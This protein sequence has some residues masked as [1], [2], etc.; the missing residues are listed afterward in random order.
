M[1]ENSVVK[2][3]EMLNE[4]KWT[5]A[6]LNSYSITNLKDLDKIIKQAEE[7]EASDEIKEICDDHLEHTKNSII[8]LYISGIIA[9]KN[10]LVDD[11]NL[12]I[13]IDIFTGNHKWNIVEFLC[14]RI[15]DFGE[16][17]YAL[18]TL[19]E[20]YNNENE[21]EKMHQIWE[22]LIAVDYEEAAIVKHL[23]EIYEE[24]ND[25]ET[26]IDYY[27]KA[28]HR[29]INQKAFASIK[30]IWSKL[31]TYIIDETDFFF[32][33]EQ[34]VAKAISEERAAQL[35]EE[36][37]PDY[38]DK[39][40]YDT[41]IEVLKKILDYDP[42]NQWARKE[43]VECYKQKF[44]DHS[45]LD[46]YIKV[47]NLTMSWRNVQEAIS[48]FEKHISFDAG[49]FVFHRSWGIGRISGIVGDKITIDFAK[50]RN[51]QMSLKMAVNALTVLS[52]DH[53]WVL[54]A[55]WGKEKLHDKVKKDT[56][57]ALKIVIKSNDNAADMKKIKSELVPGILSPGEWTTWSNEARKILKTNPAFGNLPDKVDQFVVRNNPISFEEK[58]F[59]KFKA[60]K[61]IFNKIA[62]VY[63]LMKHGSTESDYFAEMFN[64]FAN[65]LK[66]FNTVN[67]TVLAS[68][69]VVSNIIKSHPYLN[70]NLDISFMDL[71]NEVENLEETFS[72]IED[73]D[74]QRN[75]LVLVKENIDSWPDIYIRL[76]PY[77]LN[78]FIID[79]LI[80]NDKLSIIQDSF[81]TIIEH[82]RDYRAPFVWIVRQAADEPWFKEINVSYEKM[83]IALVHLL[84][85]TF[86]EI[87]NRK[88]IVSNRKLNKRI[89]NYLFKDENLV[90][91]IMEA[92][93]E[94]ITRI[95]TLVNDIKDLDPTYKLG[96]KEK[97][98][99][100]F[101]DFKFY[102]DIQTEVTSSGKML[103]TQNSFERKQKE[104]KHLLDVEVPNNFKEIAVA[105]SYGDLRENAEYK[106]AK[107]HQEMLNNTA[108]RLKD[109]LERSQI[110]DL[111]GIDASK[112]GFGTEVILTNSD[113]NTDE[114]YIILGPWESDP[115]NNIISYLSPFGGE[116]LNHREGE[117]FQF[118][119][120]ERTYNYIVKGI[121]KYKE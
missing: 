22:R 110:V 46:E 32:Q 104:L 23:A 89:Q 18:R 117:S 70:P 40:D 4:E 51:H 92:D 80:D 24:K 12:I 67:E 14:E 38:K 95:F 87:N 69:I 82:Y 55:V 66:S 26:A 41:A 10:H 68:F 99:S 119:I 19:A 84:D 113:T 44:S 116:L 96:L 8:A 2:L 42:K 73:S 86:R 105:R 98:L 11:S 53:I 97:I 57:W 121:K 62:V 118:T 101:P 29:D 52:K 48:D 111:D 30:E 13:L 39:E 37:Y 61:S 109:E 102:G 64:Y 36:I 16:N 43:I 7:E 120:N 60:E 3:N 33:I 56:A 49:N 93:E 65:I 5:R 78:R 47:S 107:E 6:T 94:S 90:E 20:C 83:L 100:R 72:K 34:K 25:L 45:H 1:P 71:F 59:N 54:K 88:D 108:G 79:E 76:F 50:K 114:K 9:L 106:A 21:D 115:S 77:F 74:I 27:K 58:S 15:L 63:D 103:V 85:I 17:K 75:F 31:R 81:Q 91:F 28:V 112:I 35:L